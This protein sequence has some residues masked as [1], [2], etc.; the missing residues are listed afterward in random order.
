[1]LDLKKL[2]ENYLREVL[3]LPE[4]LIAKI[5]KFKNKKKNLLT[6]EDNKIINRKLI[7]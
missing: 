6:I 1:M 7:E 3:R 5:K 4:T 2:E